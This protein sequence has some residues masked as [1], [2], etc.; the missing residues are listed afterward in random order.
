MTTI[1]IMSDLHTEFGK[2]P[3]DILPK[4]M[5]AD[6][7]IDAGDHACGVVGIMEAAEWFPNSDVVYVAGNHEFYGKRFLHRHYEKMKEKA[8]F[9][10]V[11]F[12]QNDTWI[13]RSSAGNVRVI[14]ATLWTDYELEGNSYLTMLKAAQLMN[15]YR[16]IY[17]DIRKPITTEELRLEHLTSVSYI[18]SELQ[19]PF[20]GAT[21]VV[22]HHGPSKKS[23]HPR[24]GNDSLNACYASNLEGIMHEYAPTLWIHGHTHDSHMYK[25][26][27]TNVICN[28]RGYLGHELNPDFNPALVVE[29]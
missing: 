3:K 14:G 8:D 26:G 29:I 19:K 13:Y 11:H 24:Y 1:Q 6:I 25:V 9:L 20:D 27:N 2:G 23:V 5:K 7:V 22:T 12:L 15:D 18:V 10:G 28:P 16:Q 17:T 4:D 21:I